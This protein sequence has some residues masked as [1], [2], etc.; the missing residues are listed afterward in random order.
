M[1]R[2]VGLVVK[3]PAFIFNLYPLTIREQQ[4]VTSISNRRLNGNSPFRQGFTQCGN[5][6]AG[7]VNIPV[8]SSANI[9]HV[10]PDVIFKYTGLAFIRLAGNMCGING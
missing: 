7:A 8:T 5:N 9:F 2:A 1:F 4:N 3:L 6:K 10:F